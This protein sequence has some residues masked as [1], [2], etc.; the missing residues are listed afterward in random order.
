M[1]FV[2]IDAIKDL[3]TGS[4]WDK[5]K[6]MIE[7]YALI[8]AIIFLALNLAL[9]YPALGTLASNPFFT[10]LAGA[11]DAW[12][13]VA[14]T[15][16]LFVFSYLINHLSTFSLGFASGEI[17]RD[18]PL[19]GKLLIAYQTLRFEKLTDH[20]AEDADP[21][22][23]DKA[24]FCLAYEFPVKKE[25]L[26]L[27][28]LG[29]LLLNPSYYV[30]YQ[31]GASMQLAWPIIHEKLTDDDKTVKAI[32]GNW[33]ALLFFTSLYGLLIFVAIELISV[34]ALGGKSIDLWQIIVLLIFAG[35]FYYTSLEEARQWG[36]GMRR[37]FDSHIKEAFTDLGME[38]LKDLT[39][40]SEG[41]N[42]KWEAVLCW[43]AYGAIRGDD[44]RPQKEWYKADPAPEPWPKLKYPEFLHVE[45]IPRSTSKELFSKKDGKEHLLIGKTVEYL[46][47][48][49]NTS[50]GENP[51]SGKE[52]YLLVQDDG[53]TPPS[54]ITGHLSRLNKGNTSPA[55]GEIPIK[56]R[57]V[58][59][60]PAGVLFPLG[61]VPP[62]SS[63]VL[64]YSFDDS[65]LARVAV[66]IKI[67]KFE[68]GE[69]K[70]E[71]FI[72]IFPEHLTPNSGASIKIELL[73]DSYAGLNSYAK[74]YIGQPA[75]LLVKGVLSEGN[76][77]GDWSLNSMS[78]GLVK[79]RL[80]LDRSNGGG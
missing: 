9:V 44:F 52:A 41:Y 35:V 24:T 20:A 1:S 59:G 80:I 67:K 13:L 77:A 75:P 22:K 54:T 56:G 42:S 60:K 6:E 4:T 79:I 68:L 47:A 39:P 27:T 25:E 16:V 70:I 32:Q 55:F 76:R 78:N 72:D 40:A 17:F 12:K 64:T 49:T 61:N 30:A 36:R 57:R 50:T 34:A 46:F 3:L 11:A 38:G 26:G 2:P 5:F 74:L 58:P 62:G 15:I 8:N 31:Y 43:L 28:K 19:I 45:A 10:A 53:V 21:I 33:T 7:P 65:V 23:R 69:N 71:Q 18:S 63:R 14:G 37:I 66:S 48:V 29:N 51:L 73:D